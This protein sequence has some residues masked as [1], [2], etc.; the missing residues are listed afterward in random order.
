MA[1]K[2][3]KGR[4]Q[5]IVVDGDISANR[6]TGARQSEFEAI[7]PAY[8]RLEQ[9]PLYAA[10]F[11]VAG[12]WA[13]EVVFGGVSSGIAL[14]W[15]VTKTDTGAAIFDTNLEWSVPGYFP[16]LFDEDFNISLRSIGLGQVLICDYIMYYTVKK[17]TELEM[18]QTLEGYP[19][20]L[21]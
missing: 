18:V 19:T 4:L 3:I 17:Y 11:S 12:P 6:S 9:D 14:K 10:S 7:T 13:F 16:P 5:Q 8:I 20:G 15:Q 1:Y 21:I 2:T